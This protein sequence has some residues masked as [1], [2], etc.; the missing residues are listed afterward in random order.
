MVVKKVERTWAWAKQVK[1]NIHRVCRAVRHR[2]LGR[3]SAPNSPSEPL[4]PTPLGTRSDSGPVHNLISDRFRTGFGPIF[5][6]RSCLLPPIYDFTA[7]IQNR[8]RLVTFGHVW[9]LSRGFSMSRFVS[10]RRQFWPGWFFRIDG[11]QAGRSPGNEPGN[12]EF[13]G[14]S[15]C[16]QRASCGKNRVRDTGFQGYSGR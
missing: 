9:S 1:E 6:C 15:A 12:P 7:K 13:A 3:W 14:G 4:Q 11:G 2:V 8:S 10:R 5:P 16:G